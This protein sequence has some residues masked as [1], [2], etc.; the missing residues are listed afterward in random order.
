MSGRLRSVR[1]TTRHGRDIPRLR[2]SACVLR[3]MANS[4][5]G[6]TRLRTTTRSPSF[7]RY[8]EADVKVFSISDRP[9]ELRLRAS[10]LD[11]RAG[12]FTGFEGFVR[13]HNDG[14][15]VSGLRY[16][17]YVDL[18]E[19]EGAR[20]LDEARAQFDI[21]AASPCI[22]SATCALGN[23]GLGR[24]R[25]C[26]VRR[27]PR[28]PQAAGSSTRSRHAFRSGSASTT[29][30]ETPAGCIRSLRLELAR[31]NAEGRQPRQRNPGARITHYRCCLPALAGFASYRRE[32]A[33]GATVERCDTTI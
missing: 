7:P 1:S 27:M 18:A 11:R 31:Q 6:A 9:F 17:A 15:A 4:R 12:A 13:N 32:G 20:I 16:E 8:R 19:A 21:V 14:R 30:T 25:R 33:D 22:E 5:P 26:A 2:G 29:R 28:S 24:R 10:L 3:G 23:C